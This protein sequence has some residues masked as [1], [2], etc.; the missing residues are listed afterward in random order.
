ME[1]MKIEEKEKE[2]KKKMMEKGS[3]ETRCLIDG[4]PCLGAFVCESN[5]K[6]VNQRLVEK[7]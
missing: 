3:R 2:E 5:N 1:G 4:H 7:F 6:V